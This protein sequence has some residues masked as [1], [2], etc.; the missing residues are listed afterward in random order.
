MDSMRKDIEKRGSL[1]TKFILNSKGNILVLTAMLMF[2][3]I[4]C[5][6]FSIDIAQVLTARTQLQSA[7]DAAALAGA[8]GLLNSHSAA[9]NRA[10]SI[11]S[12]NNCL[13]QTV[14]L[15]G[16]DVTFPATRR[17]QVRTTRTVPLYF[18]NVIGLTNVNITAQATAEVKQLSGTKG[19]RPFCI[20]QFPWV[21]GDPVLLK[22]GDDKDAPSRTACWHYPVDFPAI[23]RGNPDPGANVYRDNIMYGTDYWVYTGDELQIEPGN[24]VGPTKQGVDYIID[25]DPGA[26]WNGT[27]IDNSLFPGNTSPRII[28]VPYFDPNTTPKGGR[29]NITVTGFGAFFI[30]GMTGK[31]LNGIFL[32]YVTNEG[33]FGSG[34]GLTSINKV[35]LIG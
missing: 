2:V 16:G 19:L 25:Q 21:M 22:A 15:A 29:G 11:A 33:E 7:V 12:K 23:N 18:A 13:N 17:I 5:L 24:M 35:K 34:G 4:L 9:T 31:D 30:T 20:P 1:M 10:V 6:S 32:E 14:N 26:Y 3:F 8:S 27:E 28:K